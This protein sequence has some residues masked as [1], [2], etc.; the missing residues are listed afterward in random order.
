MIDS[1]TYVTSRSLT[2]GELHRATAVIRPFLV[3][4]LVATNRPIFD[5]FAVAYIIVMHSADFLKS[6]G[7][8]CHVQQMVVLAVLSVFRP[9]FFIPEAVYL[10]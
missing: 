8:R 5:C 4:P 3:G 9:L 1:V 10:T 6:I 7:A 2:V